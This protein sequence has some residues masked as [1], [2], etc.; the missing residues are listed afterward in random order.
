[1]CIRDSYITYS[2]EQ[3]DKIFKA[4]GEEGSAKIHQKLEIM[5]TYMKDLSLIHIYHLP[6][7]A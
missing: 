3:W 2:Q 1:M 5:K 4:A 6:C 7:W